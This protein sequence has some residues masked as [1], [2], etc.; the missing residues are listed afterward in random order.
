M[1]ELESFQL[2]AERLMADPNDLMLFGRKKVSL[3]LDATIS[4][5][6][7]TVSEQADQVISSSIV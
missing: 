7:L 6:T 4:Q 2:L 5:K 3:S 1:Y